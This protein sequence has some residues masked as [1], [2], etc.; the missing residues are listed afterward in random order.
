M[1][2]ISIPYLYSRK[3]WYAA[4]ILAVLSTSMGCR[5]FLETESGNRISIDQ[6][7]EDFEGARTTLVGCY[8]NLKESTY[9][10]RTF[11]LY[12]E[13]TG[14]NIRFSRSND[15]FLLISYNFNNTTL[16][17]QNDMTSFYQIAY[18]T[19]YRANNVIAFADKAA[20]ASIAQ[21]NRMRADAYTFRAL[22]HFDLVRVFAQPYNFSSGATH[23]GI[24][25]RLTNTAG[26]EP[27]PAPN[28]VAEVYNQIVQDLDSARLL[29][30]NSVDIYAGGAAQSWL[31]A[32]AAAAFL[33][34]VELYRGNHARAEAL[35]TAL[36][37][38]NRYALIPNAAYAQ[39]WR[40]GSSINMDRE[41]IFYLFA[42]T[43][44]NQASYGDNFNPGNTV[45]GYMAG[46]KDLFQLFAANDVRDTSNLFTKR[47]QSGTTYFYTNKYQGQNDSA[48][49]QKLIRMS[50][51]YLNRAEARAKQNNLSGALSDVNTIRARANPQAAPWVINNSS[52]L[53][54]SILNERR[55]ELCFEGHLFF[56][57]MRNGK[58]I[59]RTD[60]IGSNCNV[61]YPSPLFACPRPTDR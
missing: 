17:S 46:S 20:D 55:R 15:P 60:C 61:A 47:I 41:A 44:I 1:T 31:S 49:N 37:A 36:I 53:V 59:V 9:W 10:Q 28:T 14:G 19:I 32:D 57:L 21:R 56:D 13:V 12:P 22:A 4:L 45:F 5:K 8:D 52:V 3:Y 7:F 38:S 33:C 18:N 27:I 6:I 23:A 58:S 40:R 16:A 48:N 43:D 11:T 39:S 2:S 54:D 51:I 35:A 42:R 50:E 34:R 25:L 29:F 26:D 24:A 30:A